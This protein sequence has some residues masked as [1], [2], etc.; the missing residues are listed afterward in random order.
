MA[1]RPEIK[2]IK[3][4]IAN[5]EAAKEEFEQSIV[6]AAVAGMSARAIAKAIGMSGPGV[7]AIIRRGGGQVQPPSWIVYPP[8]TPEPEWL[9]EVD[10]EVRAEIS[11]KAKER[12]EQ[13]RQQRET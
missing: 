2:R 7:A 9:A 12:A 13:R 5:V 3:R 8:Q 4:A 1:E 6:A 11:R 10:A